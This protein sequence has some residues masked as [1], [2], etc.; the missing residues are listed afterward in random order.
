MNQFDCPRK[1]PAYMNVKTANPAALYS[2]FDAK[3]ASEAKWG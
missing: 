1:K 2:Q 3:L